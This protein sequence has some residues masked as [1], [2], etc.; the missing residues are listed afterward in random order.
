MSFNV[1]DGSQ[2]RSSERCNIATFEDGGKEL[3][4]QEK[5]L[6]TGKGKEMD[7][8]L[9]PPESRATLPIPWFEPT[10]NFVGLPACGTAR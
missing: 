7:S 5:S 9:Q 2:H 6:T 4:P 1:E 8:P 3:Q 10:E